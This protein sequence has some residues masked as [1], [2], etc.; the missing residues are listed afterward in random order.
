MSVAASLPLLLALFASSGGDP[1]EPVRVPA[2]LP[3][4]PHDVVDDVALTPEFPEDPTVFLGSAG[5]MSLFL[6]SP[7]RGFTWEDAGRGIR[8]QA[9]R[10]FE[11]AADWRTSRTAFAAVGRGGLHRT[12]DGGQSWQLVFPSKHLVA[13]CLAPADES[14]SQAMF[15]ASANKVWR[16]GDRGDTS[17]L[18][19][20]SGA[21]TGESF[22]AVA[23]HLVQ[24]KEVVF[25]GT[26]DRR[27]LRRVGD[28]PWSVTEIPGRPVRIAISPDF[29]R[30]LTMWVATHG[31][32]V[33]V[34]TD[35][36]ASFASSSEGIADV[37]VNYV[38]AAPSYPECRDLFAA[39]RD[40]GVY[41]SPDGGKT[42]KLTALRVAKTAQTDN[43]FRR[44]AISPD[45]PAD[46][47]LYC[48][49]YEGLY[50][51]FDGGERWVESNINPTRIG[52]KLVLS[53]RFAEDQTIFA[54]TYGNPFMVSDDGGEA[55]EVRADRFMAFSAYCIAV[56]PNYP[57]EKIFLVGS[58]QGLE[59][60]EDGGQTW[61]HQ[62]LEPVHRIARSPPEMRTIVFSP[63]FAEDRKVFAVSR[64]GFYASVDAGKTWKGY[65]VP[66][67]SAYKLALPPNWPEDPQIFLGGMSLHRT[68]DGGVSWSESLIGGNVMAIE[69]A[70][71]W[72]ESGE[73]F[74]V[75]VRS[76]LWRSRDRGKTWTEFP[77]VFDGYVPSTLRL[78]KTFAEDGTMFVTTL[79]GGMFVSRDR[80]ETWSRMHELGS[81]VDTGYALA[82]S[83]AFATDG[84]MFVGTF[85]GFLRSRD[86]GAT[87]TAVTD[88]EFYDEERAPWIPRGE[89]WHRYSADPGHFCRRV[90]R[91]REAGHEMTL[92]FAGTGVQIFGSRGK[93]H[94]KAE[95]W[96][97]GYLMQ[98]LDLYSEELETRQVLF[99]M[100]DLPFGFHEVTI[101]VLGE[102]RE[103]AF[104]Q[105]VAVDAA[106][107][108]YRDPHLQRATLRTDWRR[109]A[110]PPGAG[111]R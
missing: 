88:T 23:A 80:G 22:T 81:P 27:V 65:E 7:N 111:D 29:E 37:D 40:A 89:G 83:P 99:D 14:G 104:N 55:W 53:P 94:G 106:F 86:A 17:D 60:T 61:E 8:G 70:P 54:A 3:H 73:V 107:V 103:E 25:V 92:P 108:S 66:T 102:K 33:L 109:V 6:R 21:S 110:L 91:S 57:E 46:P 90:L 95:V 56:A 77:D 42:W 43:H 36:G 45:Y 76:S 35:G 19:A 4:H 100:Q 68:D 79:N 30:D 49:T 72:G 38:L 62:V 101:R 59:R 85:E 10:E 20:T 1:T 41:R 51:S 52:R 71:D 32:G 74:A 64:C 58:T 63:R 16:S 9:V 13:M 67:A 50:F 84:T 97:D 44:L 105:W 24:D 47:T 78:T 11:V 93:N 5:S 82:L 12:T 18:I 34:S 28:D 2:P 98:T 48:G 69:C 15:F 31:A 75:T 96:L 39:T 87:W 26:G